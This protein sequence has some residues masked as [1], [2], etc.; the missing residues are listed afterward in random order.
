MSCLFCQGCVQIRSDETTAKPKSPPSPGTARSAVRALNLGA[1]SAPR[2]AKRGRR[3]KAPGAVRRPRA[4]RGPPRKARM[5]LNCRDSAA[6]YKRPESAGMW[7]STYWI[8]Q[9]S[10]I[11]K[12]YPAADLRIHD[13]GS[14]ELLGQ[15]S[16]IPEVCSLRFSS[17]SDVRILSTPRL[18]PAFAT[19]SFDPTDQ[20]YPPVALLLYELSCS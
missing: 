8:Q 14:P 10:T 12:I 15:L 17:R 13:V 9:F 11:E 16:L 19:H 5:R 2:R 6:A 1:R 18:K 4:S 20:P 7:R 3:R